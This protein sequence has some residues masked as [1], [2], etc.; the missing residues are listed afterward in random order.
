MEEAKVIRPIIVYT[1]C[2]V[3]NEDLTMDG[4]KI[5]S[6]MPPPEKNRDRADILKLQCTST[7]FS[8]TD[9]CQDS[10][11]LR[12]SGD[13][14]EVYEKISGNSASKGTAAGKPEYIRSSKIKRK[15]DQTIYNSRA[16]IR[17]RILTAD[18]PPFVL[19]TLQIFKELRRS[20]DPQR[21]KR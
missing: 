15:L 6:A 7:K 18:I 5:H 16:L 21:A 20:Y 12:I 9:L 3:K 8:A 2:F 10:C 14:N 19:T 1:Y 11:H 17:V 4:M 13:D